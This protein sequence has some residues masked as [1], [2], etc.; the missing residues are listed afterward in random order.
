MKSRH[1]LLLAVFA[2]LVAVAL[3]REPAAAPPRP[4]AASPTWQLVKKAT[5]WLAVL[6]IAADPPQEHAP[7][8]QELPDAV[9]NAP[10]ERRAG[11]DGELILSHA[12]GW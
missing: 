10:A 5:W 1:L 9:V 7:P 6:R 11:P 4:R 8:I 12:Q 3:A 2:A